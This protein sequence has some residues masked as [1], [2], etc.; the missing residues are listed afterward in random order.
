MNTDVERKI[1][2]IIIYNLCVWPADMLHFTIFQMLRQFCQNLVDKSFCKI[3][4]NNMK[5]IVCKASKL[6]FLCLFSQTA[7]IVT[8]LQ[9]AENTERS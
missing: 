3:S 5:Y 9:N 4:S 8:F 6:F 1:I 2:I 7:T